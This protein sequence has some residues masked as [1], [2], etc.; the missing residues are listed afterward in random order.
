[1]TENFFEISVIP[2]AYLELFSDFI[3]DITQEAIE[4]ASVMKNTLDNLNYVNMQDTC[5]LQEFL[6]I[7]MVDEDE[8][9]KL[10]DL[11]REFSLVLSERLG[12]KIGFAYKIEKQKNQDWINK[13]KE[14]VQP[15]LCNGFYIHPSWY[16]P[17][18]GCEN[19]V[20]DPAL[21]FGSGHH[22]TTSMCID[23]ISQLDLKDKTILDVGCGSGILSLVAKRKGASV[24]L[25]DTD[26]LAVEE[27]KKNFL[28]NNES[29]D[30]IWEGSIG[31][32]NQTYDVIVANILADV[33]KILYNDFNKALKSGSIIIL[34]GILDK[35]KD[36]IIDKFCDF[37]LQE[38][39]DKDEWVALKMIKK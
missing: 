23:F 10:I 25:C 13:Y 26:S 32:S 34:S 19:I 39:K 1:M 5:L 4:E 7:R 6:I 14:G 38:I 2:N 21:A 18:D 30:K 22:A 20:I 16:P 3:L 28:L 24:H 36:S 37:E 12:E 35:Y 29:I 15:I 9:L 17:K 33:I 27:S 31:D 8:A 11:L